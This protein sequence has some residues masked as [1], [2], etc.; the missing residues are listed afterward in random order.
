MVHNVV[1][2]DAYG[3]PPAIVQEP[4]NM[5]LVECINLMVMVGVLSGYWI[6]GF[7]VRL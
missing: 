1:N 2:V 6:F 5:P 4:C 7:L 3:V